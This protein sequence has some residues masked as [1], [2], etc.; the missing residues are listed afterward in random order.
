MDILLK[1]ISWKIFLLLVLPMFFTFIPVFGVMLTVVWILAYIGWIYSI[2]VT[3]HSLLPDSVKPDVGYFK[4]N[5]LFNLVV[6][7]VLLITGGYNS[8]DGGNLNW[9]FTP[10][11]FYLFWSIIYMFGFAARM[12]ESVIEGKV[13]GFSDSTKGFFCFWFF[14]W[15]VWI[16]QPAVKMVLEKYKKS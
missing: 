7:I 10:V 3:M 14:P 9:L 4:F 8:A 16:I 5:C 12:L 1:L 11:M 13:V 2:G 15:G 6:F